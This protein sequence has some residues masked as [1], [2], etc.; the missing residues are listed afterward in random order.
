M[1]SILYI[2]DDEGLARLMQKALANHAIAVDYASGG[3]ESLSKLAAKTYDVIALDHN[4]GT[5]TGLDLIPQLLEASGGTPI[6]YVTGCDDANIVMSAP[7]SGASDY[8]WKDMH[9]H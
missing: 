2:D 1:T 8:V 9:G 7:R 5:E 4:L 3:Q 6:I